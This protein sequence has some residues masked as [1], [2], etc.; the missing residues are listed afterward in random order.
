MKINVVG[1]CGD[2]CSGCEAYPCIVR[3][4][5][6]CGKQEATTIIK[7]KMYCNRC[8]EEINGLS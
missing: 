3:A 4:S 1:G 6:G 7:G 8:A 2:I 5:S